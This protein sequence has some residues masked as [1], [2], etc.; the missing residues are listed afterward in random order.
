MVIGS[1]MGMALQT[2][3]TNQDDEEEGEES[4]K[5]AANGLVG[6]SI[7]NFRTVQGFGYDEMIVDKYA[8]L[9]GKDYNTAVCFN[10]KVG[11][12]TGFSQFAMFGVFA[13]IFFFG[14]MVIEDNFPKVKAES[15]LTAMFAILFGASQMGNASAMGPD[16]GKA[17]EAAKRVFKIIDQD[18]KIDAIAL[19]EKK[20]LK[21]D[22]E[23]GVIEFRDVWFRYPTRPDEFVLRGLTLKIEAGETVALVGESGCGK[24]T[25][26]NLM[27]RFYDPDYGQILLDGVDIKQYN[28]HALRKHVSLV[29]QEPVLFNYSILEN[30]LY[31]KLDAL[32]SEVKAAVDLANA[33]EFIEGGDLDNATDEV[34]RG[35]AANLLAEVTEE[36]NKKKIIA[37]I[38]EEKYNEEVSMLEVLKEREQR[39]GVFVAE[40]NLIDTR[41][42]K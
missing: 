9:L 23:M 24:S 14:G 2:G 32:N 18:S 13:G 20:E 6:D 35:T 17:G 30:I 3:A 33:S 7:V 4:N 38:G 15:V 25:F 40:A 34:E 26:V 29:M 37:A 36:E 1:A 12:T 22:V 16:V 5:S 21:E 19:D 10:I 27:M 31:G 28:L 41:E 8:E 11:C 39:K 42:D